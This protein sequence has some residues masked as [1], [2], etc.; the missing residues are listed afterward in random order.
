LIQSAMQ[1][2]ST[3]LVG[4]RRHAAAVIAHSSRKAGNRINRAGEG[5]RAT[6]AIAN[7]SNLAGRLHSLHRR[8]DIEQ[9]LG[10]FR[11]GADSHAAL[12]IVARISQFHIALYAIVESGRDRQ[13]ALRRI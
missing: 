8:L 9:R 5:K 4:H 10:Q 1:H 13:I 6:Q 2:V 12:G 11:L 7:Q 3:R